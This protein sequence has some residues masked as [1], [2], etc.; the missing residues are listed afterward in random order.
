M[1]GIHQWLIHGEGSIRGLPAIMVMIIGRGTT[2]IAT[3]NA[4]P[5][6]AADIK[7][8]STSHHITNVAAAAIVRIEDTNE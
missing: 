5:V 2:I 4:T 7:I 8:A 6:I 3:N 1:G